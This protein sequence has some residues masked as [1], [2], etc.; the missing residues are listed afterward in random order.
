MCS[1]CNHNKYL[2]AEKVVKD[3]TFHFLKADSS[4]T[5][6]DIVCDTEGKNFKIGDFTIYHCPTCGRKLY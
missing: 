4:H 1:T 5:V 6:L 3:K 2:P